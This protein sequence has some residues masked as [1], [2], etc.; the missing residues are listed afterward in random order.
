MRQKNDAEIKN[1]KSS[2]NARTARVMAAAQ[3]LKSHGY[4]DIAGLLARAELKE[5]KGAAVKRKRK[6]RVVGTRSNKAYDVWID[7]AAL[8]EAFDPLE[9]EP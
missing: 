7:P 1:D 5:R 2:T 3:L 6:M 8:V 9:G 4:G